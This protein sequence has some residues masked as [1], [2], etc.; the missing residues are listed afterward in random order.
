MSD[1]AEF[2]AVFAAEVETIQRIADEH[3]LLAHVHDLTQRQQMSA[4]KQAA[5]IGHAFIRAGELN[6]IP[7]AG[8]E[9]TQY[10]RERWGYTPRQLQR[11]RTFAA[12]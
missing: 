4:V 11:F 6:L 8:K 10:C 2:D 3:S 1:D 9:Q 12:D 5:L 7:K